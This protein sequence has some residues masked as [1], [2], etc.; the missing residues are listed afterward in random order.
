MP[1]L[2]RSF[3]ARDT[4]KVAKGLLGKELVCDGRKGII[5]E[6][7][8]YKENDPASHSCRGLTKRNRPMYG[9]AG[10]AYVY[11]CYGM[12]WMLNVVTESE[13]TAG[14][15]LIRALDSVNGPGRVTK[16]LGVD[17][18]FNGHDLTKKPLFVRD[19]VE[20][21]KITASPRIGIR[22]GLDRD[23]RFYVPKGTL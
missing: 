18:R 8:A 23:W 21:R 11:L 9:R 12:H 13:G 14:A 16:Q 4:V 22:E 10:H 17:K 7:E 2:P 5:T 6:T 15:V 3:Y 19:G 20:P 1:M